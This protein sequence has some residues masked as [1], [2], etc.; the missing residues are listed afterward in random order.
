MSF[1]QGGRT[2]MLVRLQP[3]QP[4]SAALEHLLALREGNAG[5]GGEAGA[6]GAATHAPGSPHSHSSSSRLSGSL[7]CDDAEAALVLESSHEAHKHK[8]RCVECVAHAQPWAG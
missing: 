5:T 7:D 8:H 2:R 3:Q 1:D 6:D 4:V